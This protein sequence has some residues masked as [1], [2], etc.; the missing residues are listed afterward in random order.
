MLD[1]IRFDSGALTIIISILLLLSFWFIIRLFKKD[2]ILFNVVY[3]YIIIGFVSAFFFYSLSNN[4]WYSFD[5][6][7]IDIF[8][9]LYLIAM[10]IILSMPFLFLKVELI[11]KID[12][13]GLE[14]LF[15]MIAII[16]FILSILPFFNSIFSLTTISYDSIV[17]AYE[18]DHSGGKTIFYYSYQLRTLLKYFISPLFFYFLYKGSKYK[19]YS[20]MLLF[21]IITTILTSL[22]GGGRGTMINELNYLVVCYYI[23]RGV[24][25]PNIKRKMKKMC[26][27]IVSLMIVCVMAITF[28]R[29]G[30][31]T[32]NASKQ[33]KV[34][35]VSWIALYLGQGPLEFSRQMYPSTVR[36]EG[37]NSFSLAK[38]FLGMKTFKDNNERREYWSS[39]QDIPNFIFYTV[40]GDV[41]SDFGFL[42]TI[43]FISTLSIL[44]ILIFKNKDINMITINK[45]IIISIFFEWVSMGFMCNCY[46]TY[47][48]QLYIF[49][50]IIFIAA[51]S[52]MQKN[53]RIQKRGA[54]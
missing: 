42:W 36:T 53:T 13:T 14:G 34:E 50:T 35:L 51:I 48:A 44:M 25:S 10:F 32:S 30:F 15:K 43:I 40:V 19:N 33:D 20:N 6:E 54:L 52:I 29:K 5:K 31:N 7:D 4:E 41:Y 26:F 24:L 18:S 27:I 21:A 1:F 11:K 17:N 22:V 39:K 9:F 12:D 3:S 46:K 47:Y 37:D 38:T 23:F 16:I 2:T 49:L 28:A 8:S 45:V